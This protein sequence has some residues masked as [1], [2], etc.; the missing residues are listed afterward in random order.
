VYP[1]WSDRKKGLRDVTEA[2]IIENSRAASVMMLGTTLEN[3][4]SVFFAG[5]R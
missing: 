2:D 1:G 5:E 3:V 4:G